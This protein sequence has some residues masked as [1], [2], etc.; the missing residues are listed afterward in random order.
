MNVN[1]NLTG[2]Q[3]HTTARRYFWFLLCLLYSSLCVGGFYLP[4]FTP[5]LP[6]FLLF[7]LLP[8]KQITQTQKIPCEA[9]INAAIIYKQSQQMH[10]GESSMAG[11]WFFLQRGILK[12]LV[13]VIDSSLCF[14]LHAP[15]VSSV[16][17]EQQQHT[18]TAGYSSGWSKSSLYRMKSHIF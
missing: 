16:D 12:G 4:C 2:W 7:Y 18:I 11:E 3:R 8:F 5:P 9:E 10:K 6:V 15:S 17:D 13:V 14:Y 1:C